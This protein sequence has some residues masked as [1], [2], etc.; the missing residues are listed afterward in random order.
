MTVLLIT[1]L[2]FPCQQTA[3]AYTIVC[4]K[5]DK[6]L[7]LQAR[8]NNISLV[9][10][11]IDKNELSELRIE[12]LTRQGEKELIIDVLESQKLNKT[13]YVHYTLPLKKGTNRFRI[14]PDERE[15]KIRYKP[16]RTIMNMDFEIPAAYLFHRKEVIPAQCSSCHSKKLPKDANLDVK[17][18]EKSSDYSPAC[19]S[20]HRQL[21]SQPQW[22]HGPSANVHCL[23]CHQQKKG[24]TRIS[25]LTGRVDDVCFECH[26]N[27]RKF[28]ESAHVHGP[29]GT[30]DCTVCHDPHGDKYEFQL[31][32]DGHSALC[33]GCHAD[34]K[35]TLR[36]RVGF[37]SHGIIE[38]GGCIACHDPHS[39][40]NRFQ[41]YKP[42][43]ALC[44]SCHTSLQGV[45]VGHPVGNHPLSG[46]TDPRRKGRELSCTS[47]HNPHGSRFRY[48]L[49]GDLLGGHVCSKC[50]H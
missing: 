14:F 46:K 8:K 29:V 18:L 44:T 39:S 12:R 21:I 37:Y 47:C 19:F 13:W 42:I 23:N 31:W 4:P 49:I 30:G 28:K 27:K 1:M 36:Q 34:K 2:F 22:R 26:V 17:Q 33:I 15:L 32:A 3:R 38:G 20:C 35:D 10:K 40:P 7:L 41:L 24:K 45:T 25:I 9:L 16:V 48:L 6:P 5:A 50:H 43:N 11:V